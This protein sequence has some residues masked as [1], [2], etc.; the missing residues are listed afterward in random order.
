MLGFALLENRTEKWQK[1]GAISRPMTF[2]I[3]HQYSA[4]ALSVPA[5]ATL[6]RQKPQQATKKLKKDHSLWRSLRP[7]N[8]MVIASK[9]DVIAKTTLDNSRDTVDSY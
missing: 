5:R 7:R 2:A 6:N 8:G 1:I 9:S 3:F 4:L